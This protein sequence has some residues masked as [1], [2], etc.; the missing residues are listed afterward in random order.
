MLI[1]ILRM[2]IKFSFNHIQTN[3]HCYFINDG[4]TD[5]IAE[6]LNKYNKEDNITIIHHRQNK[7]LSAARNSGN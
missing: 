2:Y 3:Y 7:G 5:K 4:S 1:N 6:I